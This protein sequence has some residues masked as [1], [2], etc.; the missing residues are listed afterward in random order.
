MVGIGV[1]R[2]VIGATTVSITL[3]VQMELNG[4]AG[5]CSNPLESLKRNV[6]GYQLVN[7]PPPAG[8]PY[9]NYQ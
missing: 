4:F 3:F 7:P 8:S 6:P 2:D 9:R 1:K 5:L